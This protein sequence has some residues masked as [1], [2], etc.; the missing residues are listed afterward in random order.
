MKVYRVGKGRSASGKILDRDTEWY[1]ND[2]AKALE[3]A[4]L[5]KKRLYVS[6][7]GGKYV[8]INHATN[9]N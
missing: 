2:Y 3:R 8:E 7:N 5:L 6:V 9:L 4:L 1:T